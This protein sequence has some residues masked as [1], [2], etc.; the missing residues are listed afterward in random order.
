MVCAPH[1]WGIVD[2]IGAAAIRTIGVIVP[3]RLD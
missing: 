3:Y 1:P 2:R